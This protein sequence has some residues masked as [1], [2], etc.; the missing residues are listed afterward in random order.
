MPEI[1]DG[2]QI[3][4]SED[5]ASVLTASVV[6]GSIDTAD[7]ASGSVTTVKI[8]DGA[9]TNA[10]LASDSVDTAQ[11]VADAVT[12]AKINAGAVD[13]TELA[14]GA[15]TDAKV[16]TGIDAAKLA[17]GSVSNA[18][19]QRLNGVTSDIQTQFTGKA[20][21]STTIS[22]GT[23]LTGGGSLAANRTISHEDTS[24]QSS[25]NNS[26][27]SVIQDVTLDGF[28]HVTA[29]N[30]VDLD[31]RYYTETEADSLFYKVRRF[32]N[33]NVGPSGIGSTHTLSLPL[34][35][36]G[37]LAIYT[38]TWDSSTGSGTS[39]WTINAPSSGTYSWVMGV[40]TSSAS[41]TPEVFYPSSVGNVS[42]GSSIA[43]L[44]ML[45]S[46]AYRINLM[47]FRIS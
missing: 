14:D 3:A 46:V 31:G 21:T 5:S 36:V 15:V 18:E 6:S 24:S 17:D 39:V 13:T 19:F 10:K 37:E 40:A 22:A 12:T 8:D 25:V 43:T 11:I 35:V 33:Q 42:G 4:W 23:G 26:N 28:G 1:Q 47:Y 34:I 45:R 41:G 20:S 44:E 16:D 38:G 2:T 32:I 27:G 29:L 7:L 30:S 9:V